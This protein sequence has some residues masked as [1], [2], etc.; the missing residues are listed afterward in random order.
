MLTRTPRLLSDRWIRSGITVLV[1]AIATLLLSSLSMYPSTSSS[2]GGGS[3][4]GGSPS[5]GDSGSW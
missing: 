2:S 5:G 4:G 3:F 1:A